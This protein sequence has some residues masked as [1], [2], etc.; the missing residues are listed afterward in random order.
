[1]AWLFADTGQAQ[2][3]LAHCRDA[4]ALGQS[5]IAPRVEA[6]LQREISR[7]NH[8]AHPE[9]NLSPARRAVEL[10]RPLKE[11]HWLYKALGR[12]SITLTKAGHYD[13][14]A[15][16]IDEM[17]E[18]RSEGSWP[19]M[20]QWDLLN[21]RDYLA[22]DLGNYEEGLELARQ[23]L[24]LA[25]LFGDTAKTVFSLMAAEQCA[26][27]LKEYA[28]AVEQGQR[29]IALAVQ[30]NEVEHLH[31]FEFNLAMSLAMCGRVDEALAQVR[32]CDRLPGRRATLWKGLEVMAL[33]SLH[34]KRP[35]LAARLI[36]RSDAEYRGRKSRREPVERNVYDFV[37]DNLEHSLDTNTLAKLTKE[38]ATADI[39]LLNAMATAA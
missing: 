31:V 37:V 15:A 28:E 35:R 8:G 29:L 7:L 36:G 21:A 13:D 19:P 32:H 17:R 26:A 16:A 25:D 9:E 33:I 12:L 38:G 30:E 3:A 18:L 39:E 10:L 4:L 34:K 1:M 14:S 27:S 24:A 5:G 20:S 11:P 2:E 23:E 22:N 6:W